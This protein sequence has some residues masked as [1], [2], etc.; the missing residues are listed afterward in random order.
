[1]RGAVITGLRSVEI[2]SRKARRNYGISIRTRFEPASHQIFWP[3]RHWNENYEYFEIWG[4]IRWYVKKVSAIITPK[5]GGLAKS[6]Q[7]SCQGD[8]IPETKKISFPF[9]MEY[10]H[11]RSNMEGE[12]DLWASD[13]EHA[14]EHISHHSKSDFI[15]TEIPW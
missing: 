7:V 13:S 9:Q 12:M 15:D 10:E 6:D 1:M 8:E 14:E 11:R 3:F 5:L 4:L 2:R